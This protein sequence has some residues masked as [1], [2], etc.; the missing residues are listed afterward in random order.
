MPLHILPQRKEPWEEGA[1]QDQNK[2]AQG[3]QA[4]TQRKLVDMNKQKTVADLLKAGYSDKQALVAS[5]VAQ[6][7]AALMKMLQLMGNPN[8]QMGQEMGGR[9]NQGMGA[10]QGGAIFNQVPN[11]KQREA[12]LI[13]HQRVI[14]AQ[15]KKFND[16]LSPQIKTAEK[17]V[18]YINEAR[19]ILK[20]GQTAGA[21]RSSLPFYKLTQNEDTQDLDNVFNNIVGLM[22]EAQRGVPTRYKIEFNK[23]LKPQVGEPPRVI[24]KK[25]KRL[26]KEAMKVL[27]IGELR[28]RLIEENDYREPEGL[29]AKINAL[30][31]D[32]KKNPEDIVR[33]KNEPENASPEA[34]QASTLNNNQN[35]PESTLENNQED[36]ESWP[37][38]ILRNLYRTLPT[39]ISS[40]AS[41]PNAFASKF[42]PERLKLEDLE[43]LGVKLNPEQKAALKSQFERNEAPGAN[44]EDILRNIQGVESKLGLP[45]G[46]SNPRPGEELINNFQQKLPFILSQGPAGLLRSLAAGAGGTLGEGAAEVLGFGPQGQQIGGLLGGIGT[47]AALK[48]L[49]PNSIKETAKKEASKYY[50]PAER[51]A[52]KIKQPAPELNKFFG[53]EIDKLESGKSHLSDKIAKQVRQEFIK[54]AH[55]IKKNDINVLDAIKSKRHL[56]SLYKEHQGSEAGN[57]YKRGVGALNETIQKAAKDNP[58]FGKIWNAAED[59]QK[60]TYL[61]PDSF[62]EIFSENAKFT[63]LLKNPTLKKAIGYVGA[64]TAGNVSNAFHTFWK[65]PTTQRLARK[66]LESSIKENKG[67]IAQLVTKLNKKAD[68][69]LED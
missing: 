39:G 11:S 51:R 28:D 8:Q 19:N 42:Q 64:K 58:H 22:N 44:Y 41:F 30:L 12:Q 31:K 21:L 3:L 27:K 10:Q 7:P 9:P 20:R 57:Y 43:K 24:E 46:Y 40:V 13:A 67:Q 63:N 5:Q 15:N 37:A 33:G 61:K 26:E 52:S 35:G 49:R 2:F 65:H 50:A 4:L 60:S 55:D 45:E 53:T 1:A 54:V 16:V 25:L 59:L 36:E 47:S 62:G 6:N 18:D 66:I 38:T 14:N 34:F 69:E 29:E 32:E 68:E 17:T 23:S 48:G 56:N